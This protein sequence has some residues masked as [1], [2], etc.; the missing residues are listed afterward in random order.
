MATPQYTGFQ[1]PGVNC[2]LCCTY[3]VKKREKKKTTPVQ[4]KPM[5]FK[6]PMYYASHVTAGKYETLSKL[7]WSQC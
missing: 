6:G 5:L 2:R 7:L 4:F 3:L 1:I